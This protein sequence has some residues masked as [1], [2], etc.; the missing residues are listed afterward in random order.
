MNSAVRAVVRM[1]RYLGCKV[2]FIKEGYQGMVDGGDH[3]VEAHWKSVSGIIN[4]G[5]T[6]IGSARCQDFRERAGA[7]FRILH[8]RRKLFR[9]FSILYLHLFTYKLPKVSAKAIVK[10]VA[11]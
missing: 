4:K 8:F 1:G 3:I 2:F 6:L 5:G 11:R 10:N 9:Q 7:H